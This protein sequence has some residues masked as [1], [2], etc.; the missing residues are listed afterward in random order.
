MQAEV[1]EDGVAARENLVRPGVRDT[2]AVALDGA[3]L[4]V[5][6]ILD[7]VPARERHR[8]Q[9]CLVRVAVGVHPHQ[10]AAAVVGEGGEPPCFGRAQ[11]RVVVAQVR[12]G[13]VERLGAALEADAGVADR[14]PR[15]V[16][17]EVA[18]DEEQAGVDNDADRVLG[19]R[20]R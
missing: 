13:E 8:L 5:D 6:A 17:L 18:V 11:V 12:R 3:V 15:Q 1:D 14:L 7:R 2:P 9:R 19:L 20:R 10:G 4:E 16:V